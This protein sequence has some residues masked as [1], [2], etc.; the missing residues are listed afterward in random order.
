MKKYIT[1]ITES[2]GNTHLLRLD[3]LAA[4]LK[5]D[6]EIYVKL[7]HMNPSFSKKDRIA[8]GMIEIAEKKGF[9]FVASAPY[10]RSSYHAGD[11]LGLINNSH[12]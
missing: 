8:L 6:G 10:V 5:Y 3:K 12:G 1:S 11:A 7:E 2:I 4:E 9:S